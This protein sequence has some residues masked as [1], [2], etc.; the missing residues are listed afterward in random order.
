MKKLL[1]GAAGLVA[2]S[3][4]N[5]LAADLPLRAPAPV[6]AAFSWT[7]L[8]VGGNVGGHWGSD[9]ISTTANPVG[10]PPPNI[11]ALTPTT[12]KPQGVTGGFQMGYNWQINNFVF[13][14][15]GDANWLGGTASRHL[16]FPAANLA[17]GSPMDNSTSGRFLGT[18]RPRAGITFDRLFLYATGGVALGSVKTTDSFCN[19]GCASFGGISSTPVSASGSATKVGW[20]AGAGAEWAIT[21]TWSIKAE[22]LYADL[23]SFD[24]SIPGA[25][26]Q[27]PNNASC[28]FGGPGNTFGIGNCSIVVHHKYTDNIA[29]VGI[30][31]H[32]GAGY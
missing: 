15:E 24:A 20:T 29:R 12:L 2:L 32:F 30:N 31:Y 13:G 25:Q 22:Y 21:D 14:L 16:V 7:G 23:G 1:L 26:S 8:Y 19:D 4:A 9:S 5:A 10:F 27:N 28:G 17:P 6:V 11:D 3:S 18:F